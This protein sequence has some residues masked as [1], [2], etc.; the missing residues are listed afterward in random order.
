MRLPSARDS[1]VPVRHVLGSVPVEADG[2]AYFVVP[3]NR[4]LFFQALDEKG[5][6]VQSMRSATYLH[7]GELLSCM[8]CHETKNRTPIRTGAPP[9]ALR[10]EPS[11]LQPDVEGSNPFSY[12]L[13]VQPV[14]DRHCVGC[15][16]RHPGKAPTLSREPIKNRWY[17]SYNSLVPA[18]SY[19]AYGEAH[20]TTPGR[21][22]ARAT[23]LFEILDQGHHGLKLPAED[24][25]RIMLWL[26]CCSMFYG[27]YEKEGGAAQLLGKVVHPTLE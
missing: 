3:A 2:S 1:V 26:D 7:E 17:A 25:H 5:M 14:L 10:R 18:Y 9:M 6:A 4:E 16:S 19:S 27:V 24:M 23:K 11:R 22:G 13:L 8:G 15:H 12:P 21:F 20:R